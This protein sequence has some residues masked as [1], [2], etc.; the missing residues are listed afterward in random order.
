MG[1]PILGI[2]HCGNTHLIFGDHFSGTD[3]EVASLDHALWFHEDFRADEWL[4][5]TVEAERIGGGRGLAR[6]SFYTAGGRLVATT[7]QQ[8]VMRFR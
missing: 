7:M 3:F 1:L 2:N 4:L 5:H 6:G 8:G